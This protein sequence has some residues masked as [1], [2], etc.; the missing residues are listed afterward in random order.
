MMSGFVTRLFLVV[1]IT[2]PG[3]VSAE[4]EYWEYTFRPGDSIWKIA[5]RYT[6]TV[7]NWGEIQKLNQIHQGPDRRIRPGTRIII[8]ISMLKLQPAPALVIALNGDASLVRAN[9]DRMK[10]TL[11]EKLYSGDSV[12]TADK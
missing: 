9:G 7:N 2:L 5:K 4:E 10:L 6:T 12:I 3:L 1:A 8:P 11:G